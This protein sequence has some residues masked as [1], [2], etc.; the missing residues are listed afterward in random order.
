MFGAAGGRPMRFNRDMLFR[1]MVG[2]KASHRQLAAVVGLVF[3]LALANMAF[4]ADVLTHSGRIVPANLR[5]GIG[6]SLEP[7]MRKSF[8]MTFTDYIDDLLL[9]YWN[10]D[11]RSVNRKQ[12]IA[13]AD[14]HS[15]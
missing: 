15:I 13:S 5:L 1:V 2:R 11:G 3:R 6:D 14:L 10:R 7:Y 9:P 12:L 8:D 4:A